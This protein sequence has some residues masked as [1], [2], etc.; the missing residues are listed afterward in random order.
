MQP[1]IWGLHLVFEGHYF[2]L[3]HFSQPGVVFITIRNLFTA[4]WKRG[5]I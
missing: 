4:L 5:K 2:S 3:L 1:L